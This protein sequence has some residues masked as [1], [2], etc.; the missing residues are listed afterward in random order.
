MHLFISQFLK[1]LFWFTPS[2]ADSS[3]ET[4]GEYSCREV[5]DA[6]GGAVLYNKGHAPT[7]ATATVVMLALAPLMVGEPMLRAALQ[8]VQDAAEHTAL[9]T[10][11]RKTPAH[12]A[13]AEGLER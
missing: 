5:R 1:D 12:I 13:R 2:W 6:R 10:E 11:E 8:A 7:G 4:P 3:K 9:G